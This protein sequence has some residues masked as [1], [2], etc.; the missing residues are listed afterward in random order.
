MTT[1][2]PV[3]SV[4]RMVRAH[5]AVA[6]DYAQLKNLL[7]VGVLSEDEREY[8]MRTV[9]LFGITDEGRPMVRRR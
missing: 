7:L 9:V 3:G 8:M 4:K 5:R 2:L 1:R 6:R